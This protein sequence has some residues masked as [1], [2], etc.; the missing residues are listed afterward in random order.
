MPTYLSCDV[1]DTKQSVN[2]YSQGFDLTLATY[3]V[4]AFFI[5]RALGRFIGIWMMT[6]FNWAFV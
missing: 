2:C 4:T 3:S 6:R 1:S 5:L